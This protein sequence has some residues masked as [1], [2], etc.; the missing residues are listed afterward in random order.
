MS[1]LKAPPN[2]KIMLICP[3]S[4]IINIKTTWKMLVRQNNELL[5]TCLLKVL[6]VPVYPNVKKKKKFPAKSQYKYWKSA[7]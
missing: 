7:G 6:T 2:A 5:G 1:S 4:W 3:T